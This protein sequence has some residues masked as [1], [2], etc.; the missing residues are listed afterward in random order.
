M[1]AAS[2]EILSK[3]VP[4]FLLDEAKGLVIGTE[5]KNEAVGLWPPV[6]DDEVLGRY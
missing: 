3:I 1:F 4:S 2:L 5:K 6:K